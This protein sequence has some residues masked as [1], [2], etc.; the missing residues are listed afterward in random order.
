MLQKFEEMDSV[1]TSLLALFFASLWSLRAHDATQ[2]PDIPDIPE[3]LNSLILF[4][5]GSFG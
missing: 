1:K 4:Q 3:L 2:I 5:M